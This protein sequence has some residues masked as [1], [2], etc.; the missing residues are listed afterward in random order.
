MQDGRGREGVLGVLATCAR[1]AE[2][3]LLNLTCQVSWC[4]GWGG[5][6]GVNPIINIP[7]EL[8][9]KINVTH[10]EITPSLGFHS[11]ADR[12]DDGRV[13]VKNE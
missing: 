13:A 6:L 11:Q 12:S 4:G 7:Y 3:S 9:C 1:V 5:G 8:R 10:C 2:K